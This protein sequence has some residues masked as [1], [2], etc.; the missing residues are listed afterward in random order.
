MVKK[1]QLAI[2]VLLKELLKKKKIES[3]KIVIFGSQSKGMAAKESDVDIIVLSKSFEGKDIFERIEMTE[4]LHRKLVRE[5]MMPVD[6]MYYSFAE[7]KR[8]SSPI[9]EIAKKE[10]VVYS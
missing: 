9:I 2:A 6:I 10:G 3:A 8:V 5:I 1:K 7:W 4:G